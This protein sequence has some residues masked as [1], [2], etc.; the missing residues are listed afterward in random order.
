M[1]VQSGLRK[2]FDLRKIFAVPKDILKSKNYCIFTKNLLGVLEE[3]KSDCLHLKWLDLDAR[4]TTV[5]QA[6]TDEV[7]LYGDIKAL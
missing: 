5:W 1:T 6:M 3:S 7:H 2:V 4:F